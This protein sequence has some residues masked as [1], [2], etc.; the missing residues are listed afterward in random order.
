MAKQ[1]IGM[2]KLRE[3][4]TQQEEHTQCLPSADEDV[5]TK[6]IVPTVMVHG[7]AE[8]TNVSGDSS[9]RFATDDLKIADEMQP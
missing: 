4:E 3:H 5:V 6:G 9:G 7:T 1:D 8:V 2:N